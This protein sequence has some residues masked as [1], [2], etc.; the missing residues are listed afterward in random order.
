MKQPT[1]VPKPRKP[2]APKPGK[3]YNADIILRIPRL[4]IADMPDLAAVPTLAQAAAM[5]D[6]GGDEGPSRDWNALKASMKKAGRVIEPLKCVRGEDGKWLCADGRSRRAAADFLAGEGDKRFDVLPVMEITAEQAATIVHES[7]NRRQVPAYVNCYLRCLEF[8]GQLTARKRGRPS[9]AI[10]EDDR[11]TQDQIAAECHV[12]QS[13]VADCV[14]A[15]RLYA[16]H[17]ADRG[18]DEQRIL[19]GLLSPERAIHAIAGRE[20]TKGQSRRPSSYESWLPKLKSFTSTLRNFGE[21][22]PGNRKNAVAALT[23][24]VAGWPVEFCDVMRDAIEAAATVM[25]Q[26]EGGDKQ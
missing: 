1:K 5:D 18:R 9:K 22:T 13:T 19:A 3:N 12:S 10:K 24:E 21:W 25:A 11:V 2:R 8:E 16:D 17:P 20:A 15:L 4:D 14:T 6:G 7:L 26:P 23:T